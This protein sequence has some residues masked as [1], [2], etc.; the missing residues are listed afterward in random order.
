MLSTETSG[1]TSGGTGG[2]G[3]ILPT[4]AGGNTLL[5]YAYDGSSSTYSATTTWEDITGAS[6]TFAAETGNVIVTLNVTWKFDN[7]FWGYHKVRI[8]CD[9]ATTGVTP[10]D[11]A[12]WQQN[13]NPDTTQVHHDCVRFIVSVAAGTHTVKAQTMDNNSQVDRTIYSRLLTVE[14]K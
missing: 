2:T 11:A 13:S 4:S 9:G 12:L 3:T 14:G 10:V 6:V 7:A 8:L 5:G 1:G